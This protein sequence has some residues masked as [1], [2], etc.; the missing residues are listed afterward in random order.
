METERLVS[1]LSNHVVF[2]TTPPFVGAKRANLRGRKFARTVVSRAT[3]L[4]ADKASLQADKDLLQAEKASLLKE[5]AQR[6]RPTRSHQNLLEPTRTGLG[7]RQSRIAGSR[8]PPLA[9][10]SR[11]QPAESSS[12]DTL[13]TLAG[14]SI[15]L[16]R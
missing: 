4:S 11:N 5:I 16:D 2:P 13:S 7:G 8:F 3:P 6:T 14:A 9:G 12:I 10:L 15:D 1:A